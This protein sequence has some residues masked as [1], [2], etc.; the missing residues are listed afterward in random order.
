MTGIFN[1]DCAS[2]AFHVIPAETLREC[3]NR[4]Y[5]RGSCE[6][7]ARV[8]PDAAR[9]LVRSD[10]DG[11]I[12]VAWATERNHHPVAVGTLRISADEPAGTEPLER[13]ARAFADAYLRQKG[14]G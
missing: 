10:Q 2:E 7:A 1:G 13:Q 6:K 5:A 4:G 14:R 12:E 9:F 8:D 11:R 3:C